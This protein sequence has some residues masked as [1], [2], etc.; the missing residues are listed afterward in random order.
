MNAWEAGQ[1]RS[2]LDRALCLLWAAG[3]GDAPVNWPLT[4]RDRALLELRRH[5]LGDELTLLTECPACSAELEMDVTISDLLPALTVP[6]PEDVETDG[7]TIRIRPLT[8]ADLA[9]AST[10]PGSCVAEVIRVRL[11]GDVPPDAIA[12]I[13]TRIE[14]LAARGELQLALT[15]LD[16]GAQWS[17]PLDVAGLVWREIE[18]VARR[19]LGE[20]AELARAFGWSEVQSLSLSP[21]RRSAYLSLA[22]AT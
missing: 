14:A 8:S 18:A 22:R 1:G 10:E 15:C 4:K 6:E 5:T 17:E 20:V 9:V 16:C 21:Q 7:R 12:E 3:F 19:T 2:P 13:D 11:A